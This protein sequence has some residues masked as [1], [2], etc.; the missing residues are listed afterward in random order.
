[1]AFNSSAGPHDFVGFAVCN[2][3]KLIVWYI[4]S[5]KTYYNL[6]KNSHKF[7]GSVTEKCTSLGISSGI[8]W[9]KNLASVSFS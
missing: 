1:M 5:K 6:M 4:S 8:F 2:T 7:Q 3:K 9:Q